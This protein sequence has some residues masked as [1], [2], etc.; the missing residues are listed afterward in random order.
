MNL[1]EN[2]QRIKEMMGIE[3]IEYVPVYRG[4]KYEHIGDSIWVS[5]DE[6]FA[7]EYGEFTKYLM[8]SNL[9][10]LDFEYDYVQWEE[11]VDEFGGDGDYEEYAY[12][13]TPEFISFL[14]SKEYDGI[15]NGL[16][17]LIFDKSK[18]VKPE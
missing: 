14:M 13:P 2:I 4:E 7:S 18:L 6:E 11:L 5:E 1:Q 3:D 8:P 12:E 10:L 9:N 15:H 17:I 16:N